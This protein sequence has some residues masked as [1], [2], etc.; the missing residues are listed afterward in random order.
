M[1]D[2]S[3]IN[4]SGSIHPDRPGITSYDKK[5]HKKKK[6]HREAKKNFDELTKIVDE[7]HKELEENDSPFRI[8]IYQ[9][10]DDIFIDIVTIDNLGKTDQVFKHDISHAQFENLVNHIKTGRGLILDADV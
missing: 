5:K 1:E 2:I 6:H 9:E 4:Q 7:A 10:G 8:C 3:K